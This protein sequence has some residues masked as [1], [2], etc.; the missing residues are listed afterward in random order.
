MMVAAC[1]FAGALCGCGSGAVTRTESGP[2]HVLS[3]TVPVSVPARQAQ[4]PPATSPAPAQTVPA[5]RPTPEGP[6]GHDRKKP[7]GHGKG[8]GAGEGN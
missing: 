1:A 6:P 7:K 2:P 5:A 4:A 3:V 8:H